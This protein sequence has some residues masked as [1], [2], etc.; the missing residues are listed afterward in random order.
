MT[1]LFNESDSDEPNYDRDYGER[2]D[3]DFTAD[4]DPHRL[5]VGAAFGLAALLA[6]PVLAADPPSDR[7]VKDAAR[8]SDTFVATAAQGSMLEVE[9]GKLAVANATDDKVREFG[10]QMVTDHQQANSELQSIAKEKGITLASHL[11]AEHQATLDGL[12]D[13]HGKEFDAAYSEVMRKA[14]R[15]AVTLFREASAASGVDGTLQSFAKKTL[16]TLEGH[17]S[18]AMQLRSGATTKQSSLSGFSGRMNSRVV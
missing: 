6:F 17:R 5:R 14:H 15:N 10:E 16:P 8:N 2:R 1:R 18:M 12:K 11:D 3:R 4:R 13:K 9:L 7:A